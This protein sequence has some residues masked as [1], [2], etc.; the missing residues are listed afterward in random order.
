[1]KKNPVLINTSRAAIINESHLI[2]ALNNGTIRAA[3]LDV[4]EN[5][6]NAV[7]WS[8]VK[9]PHVIATPHIAGVTNESLLRVSSHIA[10]V[11]TDYLK[12]GKIKGQIGIKA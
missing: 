2:D 7:N 1:M 4:F 8:L 5:A 9:H 6:P 12:Y 11:V 10:E 3:I